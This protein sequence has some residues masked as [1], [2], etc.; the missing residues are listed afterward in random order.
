MEVVHQCCAGLDVHKAEIVACV[1]QARG[2]TVTHTVE[3]FATTTSG[4]VALNAW[5]QARGATHAVLEATG[6]YWKP[7]W[8]VLEGTVDLLLAHPASVKAIP[9]R[10][11]DQ[12]DAMW[13]AD[14][15]AHGLIRGS[16]VPPVAIQE[17]RD[18]TR[19][20]QQLV[21]ERS[22]HVLRLQKTLDD[23]NIKIAG[24]VTNLLGASGRGILQ[25][26]IDGETAPARLLLATTGRLRKVPPSEWLTR[27]EGMV[28][29]HHRFLLRLHLT[30]VDAL[31][32]TLAT[33][34]QELEQRLAPFRATVTRL[35]A[36]PGVETVLARTLVAEIGAEVTAFATAAHLRAW[37]CV[38]PRLDES[39]GRRRSTRQRPGSRW[40][41]P[42][43]IQAAWAAIRCKQ[44]YFRAQY[45][46]LRARR[47]AKKA[48]GAVAASLLTTI[49]HL[50]HSP[51]LTFHDLGANYLDQLDPSRA[52]RRLTARLTA[53]GYTVQ[54]TPAASV[55]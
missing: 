29:P 26:L 44:S 30:Q 12:N 50:L 37:A 6:V 32:A 27:L 40:L 34:D 13:L 22:Q 55:S 24:I 1:R 39:A 17:L 49:Y 21:R 53:L 23:A 2:A 41:K 7:V 36:I 3:R 33:L 52:V 54:I 4:L 38:S 14:L 28:T 15:L 8:H 9:G 20:R 46:R 16:Y 5:L 31:D 35:T 19:T 48:I 11:S 10:K 18:L 47:G 25:A 45:Y 51:T 43:L 42:M